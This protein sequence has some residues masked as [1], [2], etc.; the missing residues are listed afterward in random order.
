MLSKELY[1]G[2]LYDIGY[3]I[4][5]THVIQKGD[6]MYYAFYNADFTGEIELRGLKTGAHTVRDYVNDNVLGE[7]SGNEPRLHVSFKDYLLIE[8]YPK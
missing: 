8:V 5:E 4:P 3:D 7:V 1:R 6:T 2:E